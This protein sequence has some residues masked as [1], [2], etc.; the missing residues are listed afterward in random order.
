[1]RLR[2]QILKLE[3]CEMCKQINFKFA[4]NDFKSMYQNNL[5]KT[6]FLMKE[7]MND[8]PAMKREAC[9]MKRTSY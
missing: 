2:K 1:M 5:F 8:I 3:S 7:L 4:V 6:C 9:N